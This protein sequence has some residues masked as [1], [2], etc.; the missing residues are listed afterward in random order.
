MTSTAGDAPSVGVGEAR[1][2]AG[3]GTAMSLAS[4]L[5]YG[6]GY[7]LERVHP[8]SGVTH[9]GDAAVSSWLV[10]STLMLPVTLAAVYAA[11]WVAAR[12]GSNGRSTTVFALASGVAVAVVTAACAPAL[13]ALFPDPHAHGRPLPGWYQLGDALELVRLDVPIAAAVV[14]LAQLPH[15][16]RRTPHALSS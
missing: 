6:G 7:W 16:R 5:A 9:G 15:S 13:V 12:G 3:P 10:K 2:V 14:L 11:S 4:A 8:I 1:T